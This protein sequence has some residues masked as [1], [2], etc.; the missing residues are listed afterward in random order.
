MN[1][2]P[3]RHD[4]FSFTSRPF[5][6]AASVAALTVNP[7]LGRRLFTVR[8]RKMKRAAHAGIQ[9]T[10]RRTPYLDEAR[11]RLATLPAGFTDWV[12]A[13]PPLPGNASDLLGPVEAGSAD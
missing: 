12:W 8:S 1:R 7:G 3:Y 11:A 6:R 5:R 2:A 10:P 9:A 13:E 4:Q